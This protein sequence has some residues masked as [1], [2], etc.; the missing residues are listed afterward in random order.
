MERLTLLMPAILSFWKEGAPAW[1]DKLR[2]YKVL[3]VIHMLAD[4]LQEVNNLSKHFQEDD[5]DIASLSTNIEA[6]LTS[7]CRKFLDEDSAKGTIFLKQIMS[8]I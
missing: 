8:T 6:T 1:Y 3:F 5:V 2:I 7:L 4:V